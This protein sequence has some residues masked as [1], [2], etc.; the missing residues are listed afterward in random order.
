MLS[1]SGLKADPTFQKLDFNPVTIHWW[2]ALD[3]EETF[4]K[5][6]L[7]MKGAGL[8][9]DGLLLSEVRLSLLL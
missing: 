3:E 8:K 6:L 9:L 1:G 4:V 7:T 2:F 5:L